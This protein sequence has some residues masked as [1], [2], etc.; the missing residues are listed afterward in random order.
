MSKN[1]LEV[2]K[3]LQ[4]DI[5]IPYK[6]RIQ[7]IEDYIISIADGDKACGTGKEIIYPSFL[8][9]KHSFADGVYIREM[10]I[11]EGVL[12]T[13]GIHKYKEAFFLLQGRLNI[14][15]KSGVEEY[16]A[17]CYVIT[18]PGSKKMGYAIEES[19]VVT[20]H[21]NPTN[22]EDLKEL[23]DNM[24]VYNWKEYNQF[25]KKMKNEKNK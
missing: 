24:V 1:E 14:M 4:G 22:T 13:G 18:P 9:Y 16:V 20:V 12:I 23:E 2:S 10:K 25:L 6:D 11:E 21:A 19:I 15:T 7:K 8:K 3:I 5:T 17:P